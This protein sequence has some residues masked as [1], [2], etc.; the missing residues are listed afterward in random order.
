MVDR[1]AEL[2]HR[3]DE[4]IAGMD[5]GRGLPVLAQMRGC[6]VSVL[7]G[8]ANEVIGR[9]RDLGV[10]ERGSILMENVDT[11]LSALADRVAARRGP[12]QSF[13]PVWAEVESRIAL[14]STFPPSWFALLVIAGLIGAVGIL[15]NSTILIVGAMVVGPAPTARPGDRFSSSCSTSWSLPRSRSS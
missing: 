1:A 14:D 10:D 11:S 12:Y 13:T 3:S 8:A 7:Q 6:P 2:G 9:L 4:G 15:T 5:A